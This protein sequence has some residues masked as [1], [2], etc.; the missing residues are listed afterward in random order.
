ML[1]KKLKKPLYSLAAKET[2]L[3]INKINKKSHVK[4]YAATVRTPEVCP[5]GCSAGRSLPAAGVQIQAL[6]SH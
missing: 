3:K 2:E 4:A 1:E 6:A 5:Y